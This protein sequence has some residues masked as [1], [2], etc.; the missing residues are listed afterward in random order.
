MCIRALAF[1]LYQVYFKVKIFFFQI[2]FVFINGEFVAAYF[3]FY[4]FLQCFDSLVQ[5]SFLLFCTCHNSTLF[6]SSSFNS[7]ARV[8]VCTCFRRNRPRNRLIFLWIF[9]ILH[10]HRTN[11]FFHSV[12]PIIFSD[13]LKNPLTFSWFPSFS[14]RVAT[15]LYQIIQIS[16][17]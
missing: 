2:K 1:Y 4:N 5:C 10:F 6:S 7:R 8:S 17:I 15:L 12:P 13:K 3:K 16:V 14:W 11:F 9:K